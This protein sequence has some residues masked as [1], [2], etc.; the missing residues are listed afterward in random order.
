MYTVSVVPFSGHL[1]VLI[2]DQLPARSRSFRLRLLLR[3]H[4]L[5]LP[6]MLIHVNVRL[7]DVETFSC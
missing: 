6:V 2:R 7:K 3:L 1:V 5:A 4:P